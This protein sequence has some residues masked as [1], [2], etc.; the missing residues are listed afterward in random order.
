MITSDVAHELARDCQRVAYYSDGGYT[1]HYSLDVHWFATAVEQRTIAEV[2]EYI[3]SLSIHSAQIDCS[4][5]AKILKEKY[6]PSSR[7]F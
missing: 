2:V 6:E 4:A 3:N 5:L 7:S 1:P